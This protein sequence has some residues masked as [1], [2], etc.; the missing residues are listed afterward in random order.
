M[1]GWAKKVGARQGQPFEGIEV[2]RNMPPSW[3]KLLK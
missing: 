2:A 3:A 1:A